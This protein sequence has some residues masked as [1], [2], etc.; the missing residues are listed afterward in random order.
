MFVA[1]YAFGSHGVVTSA[2]GGG[3]RTTVG[4]VDGSD[5]T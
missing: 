5:G 3:G 1:V 4:G 2:A